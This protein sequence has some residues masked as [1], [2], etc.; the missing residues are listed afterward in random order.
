V[1]AVAEP[2]SG[3]SALRVTIWSL[4]RVAVRSWLRL[5]GHG[6]QGMLKGS[7]WAGVGGGGMLKA[8]SQTHIVLLR[9]LELCGAPGPFQGACAFN[10]RVCSANKQ[11][12][13]S[14]T[15]RSAT[16][17]ALAP[18]AL[19]PLRADSVL[20]PVTPAPVYSALVALAAVAACFDSFMT[21]VMAAVAAWPCAHMIQ[22]AR[23]WL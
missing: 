9:P 23:V 14:C 10:Q 19:A 21:R 20:G 13:L 1:G 12:K 22:A 3:A 17:W 7:W 8:C 16:P 5:V 18:W 4:D 2:A 15:S 6:A 11:T